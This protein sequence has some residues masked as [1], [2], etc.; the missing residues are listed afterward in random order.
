MYYIEPKNNIGTTLKKVVNLN[1]KLYIKPIKY[2]HIN[3]TLI[4]Y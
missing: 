2:L 3:E 1:T 4:V